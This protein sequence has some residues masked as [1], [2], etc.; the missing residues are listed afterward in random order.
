MALEIE[1]SSDNC[2]L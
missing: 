1:F 2:T